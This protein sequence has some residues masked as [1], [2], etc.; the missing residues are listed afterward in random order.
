MSRNPSAAFWT[1]DLIGECLGMNCSDPES[2]EK[3]REQ[4]QNLQ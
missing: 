2:Q 4:R 1:S 3:K